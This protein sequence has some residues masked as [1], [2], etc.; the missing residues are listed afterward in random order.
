MRKK[1]VKRDSWQDKIDP[2]F[3]K[4]IKFY[5]Q[6][7]DLVGLSCNTGWVVLADEALKL[8][9]EKGMQ[10]W[11]KSYERNMTDENKTLM[12]L[13]FP[14][15]VTEKERN[16]FRRDLEKDLLEQIK[17]L[18]ADSQ[19]YYKKAFTPF[20]SESIGDDY[21]KKMSVDELKKVL[22]DFINDEFVLLLHAF[23][24]EMEKEY[25]NSPKEAYEKK[26]FRQSIIF[27]FFLSAYNSISALVFEKSLADLIKDAKSGKSG[28]EES[29]FS[30]LQID[31]T[32]VECDWAQKMIRKAQLT[33]NESFFKQMAKAISKSPLQNAKQFTTA[34]MVIVVFWH[35]GLKK[36]K[37][38]EIRNL[39]KSC[40][41][42]VQYP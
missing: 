3:D 13:K 41:L 9:K 37:Y 31:R 8:W 14:K 39:L 30:L 24:I 35:L 34:R 7:V 21:F 22:R 19:N 18:P 6:F 36:L 38:Y 26:Y 28:S 15:V 25:K 11:I 17:N 4:I 1:V 32:V 33:G 12:K 40:G 23:M 20:Y 42:V 10:G 5:I 2:S 16:K 27:D 29:F